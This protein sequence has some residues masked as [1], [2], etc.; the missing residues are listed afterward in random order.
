MNSD[1]RIIGSRIKQLRM[2]RNE[3][4]KEFGAHLSELMGNAILIA[5][6]TVS[7]WETGRKTPPLS[8]IIWIQRYFGV[9]L[10]YIV[11]LSDDKRIGLAGKDPDRTK[12]DKTLEIPYNKLNL[13][14][15]DPV[16]VVFPSTG[17]DFKNQWGILNIAKNKIVFSDISM[18][19]NPRCKYYMYVTPEALTIQ[20]RASYILTLAEVMIKEQVYVKS[21]SPDAYIRG[22][23]DGWYHH[24]PDKKFLMNDAGYTLSYDGIGINYNAFEFRGAKLKKTDD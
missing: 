19:L 24:N 23:V 21:L 9:S 15:G 16:F 13:H 10:D 2:E 7:C 14:D 22:K 8:T 18:T 3:S 5:A 6:A 4:Q 20:N 12:I 1:N 17:T 11:G